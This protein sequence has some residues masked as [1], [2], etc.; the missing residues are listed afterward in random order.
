VPSILALEGSVAASD[1]A[2][3]GGEART[4]LLPHRA[5]RVIVAEGGEGEGE[6]GVLVKAVE[7]QAVSEGQKQQQQRQQQGLE[8]LEAGPPKRK[9]DPRVKAIARELQQLAP[10]EVSGLLKTGMQGKMILSIDYYIDCLI[11]R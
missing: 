7:G 1:V 11:K 5:D 2:V 10:M 8:V 4:T 6:G 3:A 9:A